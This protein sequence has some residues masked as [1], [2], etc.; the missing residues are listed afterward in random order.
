MSA[1][2]NRHISGGTT[3]HPKHTAR[4]G[5]LATERMNIAATYKPS[6]RELFAALFPVML[7]SRPIH[8][9]RDGREFYGK[10]TF[11]NFIVDG[12]HV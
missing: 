3:L 2:I 5:R 12:K 4:R 7:A 10:P 11:R 8:K 1:P 6:A 9:T